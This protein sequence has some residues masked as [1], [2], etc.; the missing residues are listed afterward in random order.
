MRPRIARHSIAMPAFAMFFIVL[1]FCRLEV[2]SIGCTP[3]ILKSTDDAYIDGHAI[4]IS[5]QVPALVCDGA[6]Q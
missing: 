4:P 1:C 6:C 2:S 3:V 5:P